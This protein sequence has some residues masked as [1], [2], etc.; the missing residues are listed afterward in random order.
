MKGAYI[1]DL[2]GTLCDATPRYKKYVEDC[3]NWEDFYMHCDEDDEHWEVCEVLNALR[4]AGYD[5]L[6]VTG[7]RE[8]AREPTLKWIEQHFD[9]DIAKTEHLFMRSAE[10]G[11]REDYV[12]KCRNYREH[13]KD[14]WTVRG[15]FEDR[16]Q[17][18]R[19]WRDLGLRCY[20]V[21]DGCY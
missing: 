6:F 1:F 3:N 2:D 18:V 5:I 16:D 7:R 4:N 17:C 9:K 8:S 10:D 21:A 12:S 14:K 13:I 11:F 20:Q 15:V 19:A